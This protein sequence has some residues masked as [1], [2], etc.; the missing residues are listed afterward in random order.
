[1]A[2]TND[3]RAVKYY[4]VIWSCWPNGYYCNNKMEMLCDYSFKK[5]E[6]L[7]LCYK[8]KETSSKILQQIEN[9]YKEQGTSLTRLF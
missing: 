5:S 3:S 7:N 6:D 2:F 8:S 4:T 9:D 1:M